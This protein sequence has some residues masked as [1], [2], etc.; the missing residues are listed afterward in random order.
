MPILVLSICDPIAAITGIKFKAILVRKN[1]GSSLMQ[2]GREGKTY[3][4]SFSF[5]IA[6]FIIFYCMLPIFYRVNT[7]EIIITTF[8]M[9][10]MSTLTEA[11]SK[12]GSDNIFIPVSIVFG[13]LLFKW[14][15]Q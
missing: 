14:Y 9:S 6:S 12:R 2:Y 13:L 8:I 10:L 4:G 5:F 3:P 7:N 11:L 1:I 15:F